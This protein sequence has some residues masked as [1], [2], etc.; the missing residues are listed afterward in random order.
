MLA[1]GACF[2]YLCLSVLICEMG[3]LVSHEVILRI[4]EVE[5]GQVHR[6]MSPI[7]VLSYFMFC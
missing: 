6:R 2:T 4:K 1:L 3:I 5:M 7:K